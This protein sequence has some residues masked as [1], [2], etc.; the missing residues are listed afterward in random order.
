MLV[1]SS[2]ERDGRLKPRIGGRPSRAKRTGDALLAYRLL[3]L[4][5]GEAILEADP[6]AATAAH[7]DGLLLEAEGNRWRTSLIARLCHLTADS[8]S[9]ISAE[10]AAK[11]SRASGSIQSPARRLG[12]FVECPFAV[13]GLF[14]MSSGQNPGQHLVGD[15]SCGYKRTRSA[16]PWMA[17]SKRPICFQM[18]PRAT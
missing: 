2:R 9:P 1:E 7:A 5:E 6:G 10:A 15:G 11:V 8:K 18:F 13:A 14:E 16:N 4:V 17:R 3:A 12:G